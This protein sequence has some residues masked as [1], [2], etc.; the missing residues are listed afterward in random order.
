MKFIGR[1]GNSVLFTQVSVAVIVDEIS[2]TV[3]DFK[4]K[5]SA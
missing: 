3:S 4:V 1:S 2:N 5:S